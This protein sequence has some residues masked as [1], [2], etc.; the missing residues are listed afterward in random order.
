VSILLRHDNLFLKTHHRSEEVVIKPELILELFQQ[1]GL[2]DSI[3]TNIAKV[4]PKQGAVLLS[5][6]GCPSSAIL[7]CGIA[8]N[9]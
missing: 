9:P 2:I 3:E 5:K 6:N 8:S 4:Y 1:I 7:D